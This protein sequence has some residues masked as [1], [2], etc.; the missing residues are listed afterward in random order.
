MSPVTKETIVAI[1][2]WSDSSWFS[3]IWEAHMV[4]LW[5]RIPRD[6][7]YERIR[8]IMIAHTLLIQ[9]VGNGDHER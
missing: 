4:L 6:V 2:E 3:N 9:S 1:I 8:N 5:H 7:S